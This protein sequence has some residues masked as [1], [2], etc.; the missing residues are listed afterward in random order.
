MPA[1]RRKASEQHLKGVDQAGLVR[2]EIQTLPQKQV[3]ASLR[4]DVLSVLLV[5]RRAAAGLLFRD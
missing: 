1:R 4:G 2:P 3:G 5:D